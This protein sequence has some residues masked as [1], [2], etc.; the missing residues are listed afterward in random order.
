MAALWLV[1]ASFIFY[2]WWN[3]AFVPL[4][5]ASIAF[6]YTIS[7]LI[8]RTVDAP[9]VRTALLVMGIGGSLGTL[10]Y[11]KYLATLLGYLRIPMTDPI[12]P[13]GISFFTFTQI[14]FLIDTRLDAVSEKGPLNY[15]LFVTFFPHLIAGPLLHHREMM[16]QFAN[17]ATYRIS[18][19]NMAVGF[20]IFAIGL[21]KKT[22]L[23]DQLSPIAIVGFA[24]PGQ[25]ALLPAWQAALAYSLQL[26][27]DF[28]GYSDMAIGIARMFNIRFPAN[29]NSPYK[30]QSV[31]E[32][33]Q[34]WHMTLTRYLTLYL[35][36]PIALRIARGR[37]SRGRP[38]GRKLGLSG[39]AATVLF[40]TFVTMTF[41]G[42]W[43]GSGL[44]F[45]VFGLLHAAYLSVNHAWRVFRPANRKPPCT[46]AAL[47]RRV[48]VTY[49]CVLIGAV[50]FRADTLGSARDML[51]GMIGLHGLEP[52]DLAPERGL[53]LL[54][55]WALIAV[56][57]VVAL[58]APN[59]Q[60]I[61]RDHA[62]VLGTVGIRARGW[63]WR[64]SLGW[65]MAF[66]C[67]GALGLLAIGGSGEFLYFQ[68]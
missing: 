65:A 16:P 2:G 36:N 43:H 56:L 24:H 17:P 14:G 23:A 51:A 4:L 45:L 18:G 48:L 37:A 54:R 30:A 12:L 19:E 35:Y 6:N 40:P 13:L 25:I 10:I 26:Y 58:A 62:P 28:S 32:Y 31:I 41:A 21:A 38:G 49:L 3:P 64:P 44:T 20:G 50:V 15:L 42:V 1:A 7:R 46:R 59:T 8:G 53:T 57:A 52:T 66:G 34:R 11:F 27:F 39:F 61:M 68:F 22:L 67:L 55:D 9:R 5:V 33:W 63:A 29:F 47:C 60:E